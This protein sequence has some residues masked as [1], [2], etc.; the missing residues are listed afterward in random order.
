MASLI[1]P[2]QTSASLMEV[3]SRTLKFDPPVKNPAAADPNGASEPEK[4]DYES[5]IED[6]RIREENR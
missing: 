2:S 6:V 1:E 5:G 3:E 4:P